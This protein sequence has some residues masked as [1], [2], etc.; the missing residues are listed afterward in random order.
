M[1]IMGALGDIHEYLNKSNK[2]KK[3]KSVLELSSN[4]DKKNSKSENSFGLKPLTPSKSVFSTHKKELDSKRGFNE[5]QKNNSYDE[6]NG[7]CAKCNNP[8]KRSIAQFHHV[9]FHS[10]GGLTKTK[11]CQMLCPNC[12]ASIHNIERVKTAD[13]KRIVKKDSHEFPKLK[14]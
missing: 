8:V 12:H 5:S 2:N 7:L 3:S 14:W 1:K 6:Q 4:F 10:K 11:N 9:K 13:K